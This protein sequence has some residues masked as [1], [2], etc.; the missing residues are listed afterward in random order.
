MINTYAVL[1]EHPGQF[2]RGVEIIAALRRSA[3]AT[4]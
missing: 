2:C 1:R 4:R 3:T